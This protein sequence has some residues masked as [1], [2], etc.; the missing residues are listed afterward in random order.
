MTRQARYGGSEGDETPSTGDTTVRR[1]TDNA[2]IEEELIRES[3]KILKR[4]VNQIKSLQDP[5]AMQIKAAWIPF[6]E[7]CNLCLSVEEENQSVNYMGTTINNFPFPYGNSDATKTRFT[8][9]IFPRIV[10]GVSLPPGLKLS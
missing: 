7:W 10:G 9:H 5:T 3:R 4:C 6:T 8:Q 1:W 2:L